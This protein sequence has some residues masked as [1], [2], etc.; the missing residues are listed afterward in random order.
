MPPLR[1]NPLDERVFARLLEFRRNPGTILLSFSLAF[2]GLDLDS[3][4]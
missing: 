4:V 1:F 3:S 2:P